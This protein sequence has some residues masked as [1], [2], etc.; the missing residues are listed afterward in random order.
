MELNNSQRLR[1]AII[2]NSVIVLL[3]ALFGVLAGSL[4]L[5]TDA[6]HN[7]GDVFSLLLAALALSWMSLSSTSEYTF[8]YRRSEILAG[9]VNAGFLIGAS[10]LI[11]LTSIKALLFP[12]IVDGGYVIL[13]GTIGM[14]INGFSAWLLKGSLYAHIHAH[15]E[16]DTGCKEHHHE[17]EDLN[18]SAA[19]LHLLSDALLSLAV[20][21]GGIFIYFFQLYSIDAAIALLFSI[22]IAK[23][24]FPLLQRG[25]RILMEASPK[26]LNVETIKEDVKAFDDVIDMHHIHIWSLSSSD[27]HFSGH[28]ILAKEMPLKQ[29]DSILLQV[30]TYLENKGLTHITIQAETTDI[31][32]HQDKS[33]KSDEEKD[34][35]YSQPMQQEKE[36]NPS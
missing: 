1:I 30:R 33:R 7:L 32:C 23:E 22:W 20:V 16:G 25:Y 3:Q 12:S 27:I 15:T 8:G 10:F 18:I 24:T 13:F 17:G 9:F 2:L 11:F 14:I 29:V 34:C 5:L 19:Y 26:H 21:I 6:V 36:A 4:A 31:R 35:C 28:L